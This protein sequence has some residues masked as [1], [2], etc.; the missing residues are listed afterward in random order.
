M[1]EYIINTLVFLLYMRFPSHLLEC[2]VSLI[3]N[4]NMIVR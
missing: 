2:I 1:T 3:T 4:L